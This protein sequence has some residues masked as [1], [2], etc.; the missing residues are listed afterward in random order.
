MRRSVR[1]A[2]RFASL[3]LAGTLTGGELASRMAWHPALD[4][5]PPQARL[6]AEQAAY[7][8]LGRVMPALMTSTVASGALATLASRDDR[9]VLALRGASCG[10]FAAMIA[11]TLTGNLPLNR[12]LL[13]LEDTPEG[14]AELADV[15]ARWDRLHTARNVLNLSGFAL[16]IA[17]ALREGQA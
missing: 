15:R 10:S 5:L 9:A 3:M 13:E 1:T 12:R 6:L 16:A 2:T 4:G 17:A 7:A 14:H 11:I 8:R